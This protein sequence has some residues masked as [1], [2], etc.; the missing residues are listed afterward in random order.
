MIVPTSEHRLSVRQRPNNRSPVMYQN[1]EKLLFLHWKW[2]AE[3]IQKTL[4]E[5]LF[6]DTFNGNA[7]LGLVP[8]YMRKIRPRFLPVV[9]GISNFLEMNLRTYVYDKRGRPGVWFYSLDA[10]QWLA[11]LCA[12]TFFNLPYFN[13]KIQAIEKKDSIYYKVQRK[14]LELK[15]NTE[16]VYDKEIYFLNLV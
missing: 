6:V 11:V 7:Y 4:P 3:E 2:N 10:N 13:A 14:G 5:G 8:F 15:Y 12:K 1:W 16:I 9:W